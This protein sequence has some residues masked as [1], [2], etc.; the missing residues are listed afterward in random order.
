MSNN[1]Q[2]HAQPVTMTL[3]GPNAYGSLE[4]LNDKLRHAVAM[5][6]VLNTAAFAKDVELPPEAFQDYTTDLAAL[7][8]EVRD[9]LSQWQSAPKEAA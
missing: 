6:D 7:L 1:T 4:V 2:K 5:A 9:V 8:H 3:H